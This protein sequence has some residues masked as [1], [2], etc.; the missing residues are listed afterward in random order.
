[1]TGS[2]V[3][4]GDRIIRL[5]VVW[6]WALMINSRTGGKDRLCVVC[7]VSSVRVNKHLI[8]TRRMVLCRL[9]T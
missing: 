8:K 4:L 6:S 9:P 7:G 5:C 1:M 3:E 2:M